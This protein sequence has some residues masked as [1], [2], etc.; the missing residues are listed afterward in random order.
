MD[1]ALK[2]EITEHWT[3]SPFE[4]CTQNEFATLRKSSKYYFLLLTA[5]TAGS[6]KGPDLRFLTLLKGGPAPYGSRRSTGAGL[7]DM[8]EILSVP[9]GSAGRFGRELVFLPALL[10]IM[11]EFTRKAMHNEVS[12][13]S[14]LGQF[15]ANYRR[16]GRFKRICLAV[17]DLEAGVGAVQMGK[18]DEDILLVPEEEADEVFL[19]GTFNTLVGFVVA[20]E[21]PVPGSVCYKM[22]IDAETHRLYYYKSHKIT[23]RR[24]PGFLPGDLRVLSRRR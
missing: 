5:G 18:L 19:N 6:D 10:D 16:D 24:G 2:Q 3:A 22:L 23:E 9:V 13:Y 14:G 21:D 11:Q 17:E 7:E 15:N 20:P 1:S 8:M 12:G 4:F